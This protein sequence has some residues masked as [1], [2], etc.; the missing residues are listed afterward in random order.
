M[1]GNP[2]RN[3]VSQGMR[4]V[5]FQLLA[6]RCTPVLTY[7]ATYCR[8]PANVSPIDN[9][10]PDSLY[11]HL[12]EMKRYY[13]FVTVDEL[14]ESRSLR[15][16]AA[17]TFDDGY[18]SVID[19]ALP[20]FETLDIPFTI[21]LTLSSLQQKTFWRHKAIYLMNHGLAGECARGFRRTRRLPNQNFLEYLKN[22]VNHSGVAEAEI[23]AFLDSRGI[24]LDGCRHL[25]DRE[26]FLIDHRLVWFGNHSYNHYV[27]SSL[28]RAEQ[29]QEIQTVKTA[30]ANRNLKVSSVFASPFG[31]AHHVNRETFGI[32]RDLGYKGLAL[33]RGRLMTERQSEHGLQIIERFSP[34]E[35]DVSLQCKKYWLKGL[36][37][38]P[39]VMVQ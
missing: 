27:L 11:D 35:S 25:I 32:L 28:S 5:P 22:P 26:D 39:S 3:L 9:V 29:F 20:V 18:K 15:G 33:N 24:S 4:A 36:L 31:E 10:S 37:T 7:H 30:L 12:S 14:L 13:R 19:E 2:I 8:L 34:A 1:A 17:V 16:M 6:S 23:D 21:F 38:T